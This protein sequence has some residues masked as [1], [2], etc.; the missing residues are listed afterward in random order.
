[1]PEEPPA[2]P[3]PLGAA[4]SSASTCGAAGLVGC[5]PRALADIEHPEGAAAAAGATAA[6]AAAAAARMSRQF[7][8]EDRKKSRVS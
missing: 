3:S 1:M 6:A 2:A 7:P 4:G 8:M 5:F